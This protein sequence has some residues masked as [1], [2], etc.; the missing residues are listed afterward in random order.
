M[1]DICGTCGEPEEQHVW[2]TE[3]E[4]TLWEPEPGFKKYACAR[5]PDSEDAS[6]RFKVWSPPVQPCDEDFMKEISS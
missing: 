1:T 5:R 2:I 4:L 6:L 3:A